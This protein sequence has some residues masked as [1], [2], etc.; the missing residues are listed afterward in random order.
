MK[1]FLAINKIIKT[2]KSNNNYII[3][4][5]KKCKIYKMKILHYNNNNKKN[6]NIFQINKSSYKTICRMFLQM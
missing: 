6:M 1:N 3:Y 4:N 2:N 5:S